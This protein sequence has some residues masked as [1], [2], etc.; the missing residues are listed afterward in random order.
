MVC[1]FAMSAR[2][3]PVEMMPFVGLI[4]MS[5]YLYRRHVIRENYVWV[6]VTDCTSNN[7]LNCNWLCAAHWSN[8]DSLWLQNNCTIWSVAATTAATMTFAF[9]H[10]TRKPLFCYRRWYFFLFTA[11]LFSTSLVISSL[12]GPAKKKKMRLEKWLWNEKNKH[13]QK[14]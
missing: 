3:C 9:Q 7:A 13:H 10:R 12:H 4:W 11:S 1:I 5:V 14:W 6:F 8:S 2:L